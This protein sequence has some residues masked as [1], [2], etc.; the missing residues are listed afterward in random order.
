MFYAVWHKKKK[1]ETETLESSTSQSFQADLARGVPWMLRN[2]EISK[3]AER[4][5]GEAPKCVPIEGVIP[6]GFTQPIHKLVLFKVIWLIFSL[7][8]LD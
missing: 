8:K 1:V 2:A 6:L 5:C 4:N 3:E 7:D